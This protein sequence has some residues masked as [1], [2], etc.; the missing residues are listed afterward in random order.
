MRKT[1]PKSYEYMELLIGAALLVLLLSAAA[2]VMRTS[3]T[4]NMLARDLSDGA[5]RLNR[6]VD[7][8]RSVD[9]AGLV[10]NLEQMRVAGT[11]TT[12]WKVYDAAAG[13]PYAQPPGLLLL[14]AKFTWVKAGLAHHVETSTL[15]PAQ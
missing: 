5:A 8:L 14:N 7:S 3:S 12:C 6:F 10:R 2:A 4:G 1:K 13:P 15:L 11:D 9:P